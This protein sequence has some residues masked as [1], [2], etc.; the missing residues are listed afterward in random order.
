MKFMSSPQVMEAFHKE[1][2]SFPP[3]TKGEAYTDNI[4]FK[5]MYETS[6]YLHTNT[7]TPIRGPVVTNLFG[8]LQL[9]M[10]NEITPQEAIRRT[11]EY[12]KTV[13]P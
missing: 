5:D 4:R 13:T 3:I 8:N 2:A 10:L 11:V 9:M 12:S 1:I 6:K 7:D